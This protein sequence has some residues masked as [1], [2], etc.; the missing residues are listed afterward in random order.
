MAAI[1]CSLARQ[2]EFPFLHLFLRIQYGADSSITHGVGSVTL[3]PGTALGG[4][5]RRARPRAQILV[6]IV[7]NPNKP[8][9]PRKEQHRIGQ[10]ELSIVLRISNCSSAATRP[11]A[12]TG[13]F[14]SC[15][16]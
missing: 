15:A 5:A 3:D 8:G 1:T 14:R 11:Y 12:G 6:H 4:Y 9:L 10:Q 13:W 2:R 16:G 7:R